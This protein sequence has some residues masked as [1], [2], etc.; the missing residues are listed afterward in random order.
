MLCCQLFYTYGVIA[1]AVVGI[2]VLVFSQSLKSDVFRIGIAFSMAPTRKSR[3]V[4][5][6]FSN[7]NEVSQE[8]DA[9]NSSKNKQRVSHGLF[10][11]FF[12]NLFFANTYLKPDFLL[13][14]TRWIEEE[15][16]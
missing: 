7:L 6:R 4:N 16:V 5:R 2:I 13:A 12:I 11:Y 10:E 8:K 9:G 14:A 15:I 1:V 3:S